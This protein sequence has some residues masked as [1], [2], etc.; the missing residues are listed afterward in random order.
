MYLIDVN[1]KN[2]AKF[3]SAGTFIID[4]PWIHKDRVIDSYVV[5]NP[6][7]STIFIECNS[8]PYKVEP[9][10]ILIIPPGVRHKGIM[11]SEGKV[12]FHWFHFFANHLYLKTEREVIQEISAKDPDQMI[13]LPIYSKK[14]DCQRFRIMFNQ[15]LDLYQENMNKNYLNTY[16]NCLLFELTSESL[17]SII[18]KKYERIDLQ[19]VQ[20]WIRIHCLE[21]ISLEKIANYFNYNKYYLSRVYKKSFGIGIF[22]QITKFRLKHAK[23]L[24]IETNL[25]T[26]EIASKV[27]YE[28]SKY[29]MRIFRK[30]EGITPTQYRKAFCQ[31]HFNKV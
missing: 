6:I 23:E 27:G 21:N 19:P 13:I 4:E 10:E 8:I 14:I 5:L 15:L 25:S 2:D 22:K 30:H 9:N 1:Y 26:V 31:K 29:F 11:L 3:I 12:K 20:D 7:E 24:L 28:D 18:H 17:K 16:L